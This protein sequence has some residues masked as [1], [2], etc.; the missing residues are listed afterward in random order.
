[1][2]R[3]LTLWRDGY[4]TS[5][6]S[7]KSK[8]SP[9]VPLINP[10]TGIKSRR[11]KA[12]DYA[13]WGESTEQ[14]FISVKST[15]TTALFEQLIEAAT[16]YAMARRVGGSA[17]SST[18]STVT[19]EEPGRRTR[20]TNDPESESEDIVMQDCKQVNDDSDGNDED[21]SDDQ[22]EDGD[23]DDSLSRD[24]GD[25]EDEDDSEVS[26]HMSVLSYLTSLY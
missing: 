26:F 12:F 25:E 10:A 8:K 14:Y 23:D 19:K 5:K 17:K 13:N 22:E 18:S 2:E 1:M 21:C 24:E 11:P 7:R 16:P 15:M 3:A 6:S 9:I 4:I 20:I